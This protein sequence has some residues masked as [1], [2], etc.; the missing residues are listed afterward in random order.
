[1]AAETK[2]WSW[3]RLTVEEPRL[4]TLA[5]DVRAYA[6]ANASDPHFCAN[7]FWVQDL[8]PRIMSLVGWEAKTK[9][10]ELR[11]SEAYDAVSDYLFNLLPDCRDCWCL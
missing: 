3:K 1:M 5:S 2:T 4:K 6:K 11:S 7:R 10:P 8:K 9:N